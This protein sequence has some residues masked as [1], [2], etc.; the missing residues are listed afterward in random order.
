MDAREWPEQRA[1]HPRPRRAA[2][3]LHARSSGASRSP[4]SATARITPPCWPS[5]AN[6]RSRRIYEPVYLCRRWEGNSDAGIDVAKQNAFNFYKDKL[7]TFEIVARQRLNKCLKAKAPA[8]KKA[9]SRKAQEAQKPAANPLHP[10]SW[11]GHWTRLPSRR[12]SWR[13]LLP[14]TARPAKPTPCWS[15]RRESGRCCAR[16]MTPSRTVRTRVFEFD[17]FHIKVQFNPGR[18]TSTVAKVDAASIKER[19]CFLCTGEPAPR[20]A[21][22]PVRRRIPA[23]SAIR[24]PSSPSTS[25]SPRCATRPSSFAIPSPRCSALPGTWAPATRCSTTARN[26]A[27]PRRTTCTSRPATANTS[28]STPSV[29]A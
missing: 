9:A 2:G 14:G 16:A 10:S 18:L 4:T 1:A 15:S 6:T 7:R 12:T 20:P 28:R 21:R 5:P 19:K 27:P 8:A 11:P 3:L 29:R 17:G 22:N 23:C 26:A 24:S 25:P 13:P